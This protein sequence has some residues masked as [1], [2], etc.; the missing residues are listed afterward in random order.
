M[1]TSAAFTALAALCCA[2]IARAG[3]VITPV[4][5]DQVV[6]KASNDCFFGVTT[7][8]GCAYV[9]VESPSSISQGKKDSMAELG[10][11]TWTNALQSSVQ[12]AP[13]RL[14]PGMNERAHAMRKRE[15]NQEVVKSTFER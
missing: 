3:V 13:S 15:I 1:R 6:Q 9:F 2:S 7:P 10:W 5:A 4:F 8:Q 11:A 14:G 12:T